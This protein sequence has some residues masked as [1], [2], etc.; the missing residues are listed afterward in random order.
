MSV[1]TFIEDNPSDYCN[2][3]I[4]PKTAD[5]GG[6]IIGGYPYTRI[7]YRKR[8]LDKLLGIGVGVWVSLVEEHE[9]EKYGDYEP[10]VR[11]NSD[12]PKFLSCPIPDRGVCRDADIFELVEI[13][14]KLVKRQNLVYVHC[15]GGHGRSGVFNSCFL[16]R[17]YGWDSEKAIST[18]KLLHSTRAHNSHIPSPHGIRQFSQVKRYRRPLV[19]VVSGDR[20]SSCSYKKIIKRELSNLPQK[21]TV[22]HGACKGID[23]TAARIA[24]KLNLKVKAFPITRKDWT[25]LGFAAG[26]LRN[27]QMLDRNPDMVLAFHPDILHSKGTKDMMRQAYNRGIPV[28]YFDLKEK[29]LFEGNFSDM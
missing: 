21:S 22:I 11:K 2:W 20:E 24:E 23:I 17:Y 7:K 6:L 25:Q 9:K 5:G 18:N 8:H 14:Y 10:Y 12:A 15:W 1:I 28:W 29:R 13:V 19:V 27:R 4:Y 16:M 3:V 26:P